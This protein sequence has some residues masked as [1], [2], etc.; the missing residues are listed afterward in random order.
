[1]MTGIPPPRLYKYDWQISRM[2]DS[3][4]NYSRGLREIVG[5]TLRE[6]PGH[7]PSATTL[8]NMVEVGWE[9]WRATTKE[10]AVYLG[11]RD[12]VLAGRTLGVNGMLLAL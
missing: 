11:G 12:D 10:G 1:M 4:K 8:V 7:R 3:S 6:H 9:K 5:E 2:A